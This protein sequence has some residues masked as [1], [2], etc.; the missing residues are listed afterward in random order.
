MTYDHRALLV[1]DSFPANRGCRNYPSAEITPLYPSHSNDNENLIY[2]RG[3]INAD[4]CNDTAIQRINGRTLQAFEMMTMDYG[5]AENY[6]KTK[7]KNLLD[8]DTMIHIVG[9]SFVRQGALTA[10]HPLVVSFCSYLFRCG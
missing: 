8:D 2:P 5:E 7:I 9:K 1:N 6:Q 3:L 10:G 4:G